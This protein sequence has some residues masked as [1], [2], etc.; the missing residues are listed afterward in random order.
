MSRFHKTLAAAAFAAVSFSTPALAGFEHCDT[1]EELTVANWGCNGRG[2]PFCLATMSNIVEVE[3]NS[4]SIFEKH[5][6]NLNP[7]F[8]VGMTNMQGVYD[9]EITDAS[10]AFELVLDPMVD[11]SLRYRSEV[12]GED[13]DVR[14]RKQTPTPILVSSNAGTDYIMFGTVPLEDF[15]GRIFGAGRCPD[16]VEHEAGRAWQD[17]T[18]PKDETYLKVFPAYNTTQVI[19][20]FRENTDYKIICGTNFTAEGKEYYPTG[21]GLEYK[22]VPSPDVIYIEENRSSSKRAEMFG[23]VYD[24]TIVLLEDYLGRRNRLTEV[25]VYDDVN[26]P[27]TLPIGGLFMKPDR[28]KTK[29]EAACRFN[30]AMEEATAMVLSDYSYF[31]LV[32]GYQRTDI[33]MTNLLAISLTPAKKIGTGT[34]EVAAEAARRDY[35]RE[36]SAKIWRRSATPTATQLSALSNWFGFVPAVPYVNPCQM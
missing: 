26:G 10:V 36:A 2:V 25:I 27:D 32:I 3:G 20:V 28:L 13:I 4:M 23:K 16:M 34:D 7:R 12:L 6:L 8:L 24:A 19:K 21:N 18:D 31:E 17:I 30:A 33:N 29:Y 15:G 5:C 14:T 1:V 11:A 22:D 9:E 35:Y